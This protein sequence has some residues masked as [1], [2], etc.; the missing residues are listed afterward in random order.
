MVAVFESILITL[1][2]AKVL[3]VSAAG[4]FS[5]LIICLFINFLL[6]D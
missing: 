5:I 2:A 1:M 3:G 6:T 4:L